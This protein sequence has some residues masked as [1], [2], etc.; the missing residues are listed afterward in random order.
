MAHGKDRYADSGSSDGG[1]SLHGS[2]RW[3]DDGDIDNGVDL[4]GGG[5]GSHDGVDHRVHR[6]LAVAGGGYSFVRTAMVGRGS[7][8]LHL[9]LVDRFAGDG[10]P[11]R[12]VQPGRGPYR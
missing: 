9:T 2:G 6:P 11:D 7:Q 4:H 1:G 10:Y 12:P 5:D 8:Q 3:A